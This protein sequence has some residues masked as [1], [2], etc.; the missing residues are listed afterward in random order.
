MAETQ[1]AGG[2]LTAVYTQG[3]L[4]LAATGLKPSSSCRVRFE[5]LSAGAERPCFALRQ[6]DA[7]D[8]AGAE[9]PFQVAA[10]FYVG[11][12]PDEVTIR[13][14]A[15]DERIPVLVA[16]DP[17]ALGRRET[18][19]L[20]QMAAARE[21][22]DVLPSPFLELLEAAGE[23][24]QPPIVWPMRL[25]PLF[26]GR[27]EPASANLRRATGYSDDFDFREAFLD[28]LGNLPRDRRG[29]TDALT[30]VH[31]TDTGALLCGGEGGRRLFVS[32]LAY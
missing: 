2:R 4:L 19:P 7:A 1:L 28:A 24:I 11:S 20:V 15:G 26:E 12:P 9:T 6:Y 10:L 27:L 16:A 18:V 17:D 30:I 5:Q 21:I 25:G 3:K 23:Q 13:S 8:A 29:D 14:Q 22:G 31:V 32:I